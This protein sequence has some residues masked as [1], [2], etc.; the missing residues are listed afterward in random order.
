MGNWSKR[1]S[2][3]S[4]D[5]WEWSETIDDKIRDSGTLVNK[6]EGLYSL[7]YTINRKSH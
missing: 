3:G 6:I 1:N 2:V 7:S 4:V 5:G